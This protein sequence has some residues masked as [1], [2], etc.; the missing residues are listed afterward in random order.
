MYKV[1]R[2]FRD[3][4]DDKRLYKIGDEYPANGKKP[5]KARIKELLNG[6]NKNGKIYLKEVPDE[7]TATPAPAAPAAESATAQTEGQAQE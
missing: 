1:I 7:Q 3:L 2:A 4:S 5:T 6:S